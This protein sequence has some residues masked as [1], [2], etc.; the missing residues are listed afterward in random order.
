MKLD[1]TLSTL[2]LT[3]IT[4]TTL[5]AQQNPPPTSAPATAK[6]H[7]AEVHIDQ[8]CRVLTSPAPTAANP[9]L[10]PRYR[11]N[12][13]V[14]HIESQHCSDHWEKTTQNGVPKNLFVVVKERKYIL[15]NIGASSIIFAVDQQVP[16]NWRID[17]TPQPDQINGDIATFRLVAE[18]GQVVRLHVGERATEP[19]PAPPTR[20]WPLLPLGPRECLSHLPPHNNVRPWRKQMLNL[21]DLVG[22]QSELNQ[23]PLCLL[24]IGTIDRSLPIRI[25]EFISFIGLFQDETVR[26]AK[27]G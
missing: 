4:A 21:I 7:P 3:V 16:K 6:S 25:G 10:A 23:Y 17:S 24:P 12:P 15:R 2:V 9:N 19:P 8:N 18:P 14:C 13:A 22:R 27:D 1:A 20:P 26:P 5:F 11:Y